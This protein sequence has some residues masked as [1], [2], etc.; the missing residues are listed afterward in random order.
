MV[1]SQPDG[2]AFSVSELLLIQ[3]WAEFHELRL[4]VELD[5]SFGGETYEEVLSLYRKGSPFCRC[6]LW[7]TPAEI[8]VQPIL[9]HASRFPLLADA[10]ES[11]GSAEAAEA[12]TDIAQQSFAVEAI[13]NHSNPE[14]SRAA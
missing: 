6:I 9:G 11:F 1:S 7:R 5:Y 10:L 14:A 13:A 4:A 3:A 8:V 2:V 12:L